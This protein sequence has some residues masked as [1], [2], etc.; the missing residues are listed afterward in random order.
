M[1]EGCPKGSR[2]SPR[3]QAELP[4]FPLTPFCPQGSGQTDSVACGTSLGSC[5]E[6]Q[7]P[8]LVK[9]R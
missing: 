3:P 9:T 6:P 1:G 5:L 8:L 2:V 7:G 4:V